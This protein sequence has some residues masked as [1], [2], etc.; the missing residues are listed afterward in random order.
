MA[1]LDEIKIKISQ[2]SKGAKEAVES[3]ASSLGKLGSSL[4]SLSKVAVKGTGLAVISKYIGKSVV[5]ASKYTQVL[6][7]THSVLGKLSKDAEGLAEKLS[8]KLMLNPNDVMSFQMTFQNLFTGFGN[9]AKNAQI[10]SQNLT[11]L[12]YDLAAFSDQVASPEQGMEKL[13][14]AMAGTIEPIQRLGFAIKEAD[15]QAVAA[16]QGLNVNIRNL[17]TASKSMLR[18]I[19]IMEQSTHVQGTWAKTF[20]SPATAMMSLQ[21]SLKAISTEVGKVLLPTVMA[22]LPYMQALTKGILNMV[23]TINSILGIELPTIKGWEDKDAK[24]G[25]AS[26]G[27]EAEETGK[28]MKKAFTMGIDELNVLDN[29]TSSATSG[30]QD[31]TGMLKL[32]EYDMTEGMDTTK[33]AEIEE[34]LKPL[35]PLFN[36]IAEAFAGFYNVIKG[37][38]DT[39]LYPWL[40]SI[41]E[42][43]EEHP[44]TMNLLGKG[45]AVLAGGWLAL[46]GVGNIAKILDLVGLTSAAK[47]A[48][49]KMKLLG[50]TYTVDGK[51]YTG[52]S[53]LRDKIFNVALAAG[54][55]Y[56]A[57]LLVSSIINII[58][59][60]KDLFENIRTALSGIF[61]MLTS[62]IAF[63]AIPQVLTSFEIFNSKAGFIFKNLGKA[64]SAAM[65]GITV[66]AGVAL[67]TI[68]LN[69]EDASYNIQQTFGNLVKN[70]VGMFANVGRKISEIMGNIKKMGIDVSVSIIKSAMTGLDKLFSGKIKPILSAIDNMFGTDWSSKFSLGNMTSYADKL[71]TELK[72]SADKDTEE[73]KKWWDEWETNANSFWDSYLAESQKMYD[74]HLQEQAEEEKKQREEEAE[75]RKKLI[76]EEM[77]KMEEELSQLNLSGTA[78]DGAGTSQIKIPEVSDISSQ[79]PDISTNM[80]EIMKTAS[81]IGEKQI[82]SIE[83]QTQQKQAQ[84]QFNASSLANDT[85]LQTLLDEN[86]KALL[87]SLAKINS[88]ITS[89]TSSIVSALRK[90]QAACENIR[91]NIHYHYHISGGGDGYATGGTPTSGEYFYAREDGIAEMVGRVGRQTTVLNNEQVAD[92]MASSLVRAMSQMGG[93]SEPTVIENKLYLDGEVVYNNQ[94]KIQRSKG[95]SLGLGVFA[96]V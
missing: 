73:S 74:K 41:G 52:W 68:L 57:F 36:G 95:Y 14:L 91:I 34:K 3:L 84:D 39:Y 33:L 1:I 63:K 9:S 86:N 12:S 26:L 85:T 60:K 76:E 59:G 92:T 64:G 28:K 70:F 17:N 77:K 29:S 88:T 20:D 30:M 40:V 24:E 81:Q 51:T 13:R 15:L 42:W 69:W 80:G 90:V 5:S 19:A 83:T 48:Y 61:V 67:A 79:I 47:K 25:I 56:G 45:L 7:A 87:N 16:R 78:S 2:E 10:M 44:E 54:V 62:Y 37:F 82:S 50:T 27:D 46:K 58:Q 32:P 49:E 75:E 93:T 55:V 6:N 96:N 21:Q 8:T 94:Q 23:K 38:T 65:L 31:I 11:Q 18:Y 71:A 53:M 35:E 66:A 89:G 43:M 72:R 4:S 22:L